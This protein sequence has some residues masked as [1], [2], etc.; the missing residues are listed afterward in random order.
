M[1][2]ELAVKKNTTYSPNLNIR[3][4]FLG[5]EAKQEAMKDDVLIW[6]F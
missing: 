2:K 6:Q 4:V 1:G 3:K 5:M